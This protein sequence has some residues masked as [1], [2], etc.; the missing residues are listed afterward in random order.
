[1]AK[2]NMTF[3]YEIEF[4]DGR[5]KS[6]TVELDPESLILVSKPRTAPPEWA[7]LGVH[8]CENCPLDP[9]A[10]PYC[11]VALSLTEVAEAFSRNISYEEVNVTIRTPPRTYQRKIALQDALRSLF[12]IHMVSSGC[13]VLDKLRPLVQMHLPFATM[14]ETAYRAISMYVLAQFFIQRNGGTPDMSLEGLGKIYQEIELVNRGLHQR[15]VAAGLNDACLNAIGNLN[16][17]AQFTQMFLE[18]GK[19]DQIE[20]LFTAYLK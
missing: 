12:G 5:K 6:F 9:G 1:M 18:P 13:P 11:P 20:K 2:E 15:L 19:L 7:K 8:R 14:K 16:C 3:Q 4:K 17:Y 10:H